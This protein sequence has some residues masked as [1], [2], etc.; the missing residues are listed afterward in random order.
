MEL[1]DAVRAGDIDSYAVL[2]R[3][4]EPAARRLAESLGKPSAVDEL[5]SE[6]F[7]RVLTA[8]LH[9]NGPDGAFRS[10]LLMTLR[11]LHLDLT[12]RYY[13]RLEFT[14]DDGLLESAQAV[15][16]AEPSSADLYSEY[17]D[18]AAAW[19]AWA[20]LPQSDRELL[21]NSI[22]E[23]RKPAHIAQQLGL[24]TNTVSARGVRAR[25]KLRQAF[26]QQHVK[27]AESHACMHARARLGRY[28]RNGL[29]PTE[30]DVVREHLR[31]CAHCAAAALDLGD[32]NHTIRAEPAI[33]SG[34]GLGSHANHRKGP[35]SAQPAIRP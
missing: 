1:L 22:I 7:T 28:T 30:A 8:V 24:S 15:S 12:R 5:V 17:T 13:N 3:R 4:H 25:E 29:P 21:W 27:P 34:H 16:G 10:Y 6:S 31:A 23:E 11:H 20:S 32:I 19:Q 35:V 9:G 33:G 26:L 18:Q 2:W 14:A